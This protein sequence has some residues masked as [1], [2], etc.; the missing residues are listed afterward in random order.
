ME[1]DGRIRDALG[2]YEKAL[3][4]T[5]SRLS[6]CQ[7]TV[8]RIESA[9]FIPNV[10]QSQADMETALLRFR[11]GIKALQEDPPLF[12]EE[13]PAHADCFL[14]PVWFPVA[15]LSDNSMQV[16]LT[17]VANLLR[18]SIPKLKTHAD[19]QGGGD[20]S[21]PRVGFVSLFFHSSSNGHTWGPLIT[22]LPLNIT[23]VVIS[24]SARKDVVSDALRDELRSSD[25]FVNLGGLCS[26]HSDAHFDIFSRRCCCRPSNRPS[27]ESDRCS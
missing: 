19:V 6:G 15:Y 16:E 21:H 23:V 25:E 2:E 8:T 10:V 1:H 27:P 11:E 5:T 9:L 26:K 22:R 14:R 20:P 12:S 7:Q 13:I 24:L 18:N 3:T 4:T 17:A